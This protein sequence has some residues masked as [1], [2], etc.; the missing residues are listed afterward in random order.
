MSTSGSGRMSSE[1][2]VR[3]IFVLTLGALPVKGSDT[4][5]IATVTNEEGSMAEVMVSI[6]MTLL[7][8]ILSISMWRMLRSASEDNQ[9]EEKSDEDQSEEKSDD[10]QSEEKRDDDQSEEERS[11]DDSRVEV[12]V[13]CNIAQGRGPV[14][15]YSR[16]AKFHSNPNCEAC[17]NAMSYPRQFEP[18]R[19]CYR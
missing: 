7:A 8:V 10:D 12:G 14:Y 15:I 16:G 3:S 13:Q 19:W 2:A 4:A 17:T 5:A 1:F 9:S 18:C 6:G 11:R